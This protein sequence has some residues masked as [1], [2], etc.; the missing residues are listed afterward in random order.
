MNGIFPQEIVSEIYSFNRTT[1]R[2]VCKQWDV[3]DDIQKLIISLK[4]KYCKYLNPEQLHKLIGYKAFMR[5]DVYNILATTTMDPVIANIIIDGYCKYSGL[6]DYMSDDMP[7]DM[8]DT[9]VVGKNI[10]FI[11]YVKSEVKVKSKD[12]NMVTTL[13]SIFG[14]VLC[15]L[16]ILA[17]FMLLMIDE[18][19]SINILHG[20]LVLNISLCLYGLLLTIFGTIEYTY[21]NCRSPINRF[22]DKYNV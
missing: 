3:T 7:S 19:V 16:G 13:M 12:D 8:Y 14:T 1:H 21:V 6:K 9:R 17:L 20:I 18:P 2:L 15:S 10:K 11:K 5:A 22:S 4:G